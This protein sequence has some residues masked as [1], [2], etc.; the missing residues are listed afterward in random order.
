MYGLGITRKVTSH[1]PTR[2]LGDQTGWLSQLL[3]S[4]DLYLFVDRMS[5]H[6][7]LVFSSSDTRSHPCLV[8]F[9]RNE[10]PYCHSFTRQNAMSEHE[11]R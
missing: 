11:F 7:G 4:A 8:A 5:Q 6:D 3:R 2:I 1:H 9:W 10:Y